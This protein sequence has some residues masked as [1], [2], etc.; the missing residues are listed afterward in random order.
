MPI[1]EPKW[2]PPD[3]KLAQLVSKFSDQAKVA[4]DTFNSVNAFVGQFPR[5]SLR[6]LLE[7]GSSNGHVDDDEESRIA[8]LLRQDLSSAK[9]DL[10]ALLAPKQLTELEAILREK[11]DIWNA[12]GRP[13]FNLRIIQWYILR[14]VLELGWT[15][16]SFDDFDR[17]S[18]QSRGREAKK[19]ER[20]G[21]KYQWIAYH[22]I[23]ASIADHYQLDDDSG[24]LDGTL[25]YCGPW[26]G[27]FRDIDP[28]CTLE[29]VK[30]GSG[31]GSHSPNWWCPCV[32]EAWDEFADHR[33]WVV[34]FDDIPP[35]EKL[36]GVYDAATETNWLNL[37]GSF[38]WQEECPPDRDSHEID[39][40]C[41]HLMCEGFL[42]HAHDQETFLQWAR[43]ETNL[44]GIWSTEAPRY[45]RLFL[46]EHGWSPAAR[47]F[48]DRYF[49][50]SGWLKPHCG[51]PI[52]VCHT[53]HQY[54]SE[55]NG[56]D[57]SIEEDFTLR[58]LSPQLMAGLD[59]RW[60]GKDAEFVN[61]C[62]ELI[63]FDPTAQSVGPDAHLIQE[64]ALRD[65]LIRENLSLIWIV[66][67]EKNVIQARDFEEPCPS[68]RISGVYTFD[69]DGPSGILSCLLMKADR[70]KEE[71]YSLVPV[72]TIAT[73]RQ[74][75]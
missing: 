68:L 50:D 40:K 48:E 33:E 56:F 44:G 9:R 51:C 62:G 29:S 70:H 66:Q 10:H 24:E 1:Q 65:F 52:E 17:N 55:T 69:K 8:E 59:L 11:D 42:V 34:R 60:N 5:G 49:G 43:G 53:T 19:A 67:G 13:R 36:L 23:M 37:S 63:S 71:G 46:G 14:R 16:E 73:P 72:G 27:R 6:L 47:Y 61:A 74:R 32:Y 64:T 31:W 28:S 30:G 12:R 22:E 26:Q 75:A 35:V 39:Q 58:L 57:C 38:G 18:V 20:M 21:K 4:W 41:V 54:S 45:H 25:G 3:K 2:Q 15:S 7:E